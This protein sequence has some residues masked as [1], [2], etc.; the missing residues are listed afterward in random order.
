MKLCKNF[1]SLIPHTRTHGTITIRGLSMEIIPEFISRV[2]TLPL[3]LLWSED[4]KPIGQAAK[5]KCFQNN[6]TPVEDKTGIRRAIPYPWDEVSY[7][8]MK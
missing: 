8:V 1:L 7:Q 5:K 3:G 6:E 4:E 2:T